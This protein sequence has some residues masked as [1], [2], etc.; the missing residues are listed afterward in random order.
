MR[1]PSL[2][3]VLLLPGLLWAPAALCA[4]PEFGFANVAAQAKALAA[5]PF[6]PLARV[7]E[8]VGSLDRETWQAITYQPLKALWRSES[9]PFVVRFYHPGFLYDYAVPIYVV[10]KYG[11]GQWAFDKKL[12]RYPKPELA[13]KIP[14]DLGYAGF[15]VHYPLVRADR[16]QKLAAFLGASYFR[17]I[18][19]GQ[20]F[21]LSAR[22]LAIDTGSS[23]GEE[24][25]FF[26]AFW[27]AKPEQDSDS[28]VVYALLDSPSVTGA[29]RFVVTP[30]K[31]TTIDVQLR[32]FTRD[33]ISKLGIAPL[34]SMFLYAQIRNRSFADYR[35]EVHNSDG[36]MIAAGSGEWLWRP[37]RNP[38]RLA[39]NS[40]TLDRLAGFGLMQRDREFAHYQDLVDHF[41]HK[42]SAWVQP[43][44]DWGPGHIELV[45][46]PSNHQRNDNIVAFWVPAEPVKAG[47]KLDFA[48]RLS[49]Q[50]VEPQQ[51]PAGHVTATR[52]G[53]TSPA[54]GAAPTPMM[55]V[56]FTGARLTRLPADAGVQAKVSVADNGKLGKVRVVKNQI[57]G[58]WRLLF[59]VQAENA[60]QAVEM[61]AYLADAN[62]KPLT[63]TWTYALGQ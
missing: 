39:I 40:F 48:Y 47:Q 7:P 46:I 4:P 1:G 18:G 52:I 51:P 45:Q 17:A 44:G 24:F 58:E 59:G 30:G 63:E 2:R 9:L 23:A 38:D 60:G 55:V 21:G 13:K 6:E 22:G 50:M 43:R 20:V 11:V 53:R 62:G 8:F 27:L 35:P 61:R 28:L 54:K 56:D 5:K 42:P 34:T 41:E 12:F 19:L 49:W 29:Y 3:L 14:K 26:R 16:E 15:S 37:L 33:A 25:P 36:L 57:T 31:T 10:S 32:L